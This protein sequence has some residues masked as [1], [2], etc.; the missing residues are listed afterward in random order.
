MLHQA[1][2]KPFPTVEEYIEILKT[3]PKD[4]LV[5]GMDDY[6]KPAI[7]VPN[8][9]LKTVF[10]ERGGWLHVK[11]TDAVEPCTEIEVVVL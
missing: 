8:P 5:V 11:E 6:P 1:K 9:Q 7:G 10:R 2:G 4:A 3:Y